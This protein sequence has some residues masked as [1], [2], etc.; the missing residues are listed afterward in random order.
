MLLLSE[1]Y[2]KRLRELSGISEGIFT[3][4]NSVKKYEKFIIDAVIEFMKNKLNFDVKIIVKKK[5]N[6]SLIGDISLNHNSVVNNKFTLHFNPNGSYKRMIQSLIHELTHISQVY[7]GELRPSEDYKSIIWKDDFILS[8]REYSKVMKNFS[9]YKNLPWEKE[10]YD[11]M[12]LLYDDFISS[13]FWTTLQG[14]DETLDFI[15]N[16]I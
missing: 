12:N 2:K 16:N 8:A 10:A 14:K 15:I 6:D 7:K 3:V 9:E 13:N 4:D 1:S 11:N 5:Q